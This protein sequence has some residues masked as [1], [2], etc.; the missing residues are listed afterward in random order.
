MAHLTE[1]KLG[2][3]LSKIFSCDFIHNRKVPKSNIQNRPDFRSEELKLIVE[4]DGYK[5]F[6]SSI[7]QQR[8]VY[9]TSIY[10]LMGYKVINIPYF[11][12]LSSKS[13]KFF[14][15]VEIDWEQEYPHGFISDKALLPSDFNTM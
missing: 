10:E 1:E 15:D 14:F 13:I 4:F 8:D 9:K 7:T 12:Q 11:I 3:A 6:N 5:H 2:N